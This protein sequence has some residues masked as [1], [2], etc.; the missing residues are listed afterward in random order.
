[1]SINADQ[2]EIAGIRFANGSATTALDCITVG[3]TT[4]VVGVYIHDCKFAVGGGYGVEVGSA[5]GTVNDCTIRGNTFMQIDDNAGAA[6]VYLSYVVRADVDDNLFLTD[7]AGTYGV[8]IRNAA[9][10]GSVVRDNKFFV[11]EQNGVA[12]FRAGATV[13]AMMTGNRVA[14]GASTTTAISQ[15]AD[16]GYYAVDN[17]V[18]DATGGAQID[19]TT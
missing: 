15:T 10:G 11:E 3:S 2:I 12:I 6:G 4:A 16:S 1:M 18:S 17:W 5:S 14:G 9:T 13:D 7:Q 19:A 8:S